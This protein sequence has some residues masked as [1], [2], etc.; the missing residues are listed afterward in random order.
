M[1]QKVTNI[2]INIHIIIL[3]KSITLI[4]TKF[5]ALIE[6]FISSHI[7]IKHSQTQINKYSEKL[8]ILLIEYHNLV[9][10]T[11]KQNNH[12][13]YNNQDL[14]FIMIIKIIIGRIKHLLLE[15]ITQVLDSIHLINVLIYSKIMKNQN[16]LLICT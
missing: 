2:N 13:D 3:I 4:K 15:L 12:L 10:L 8:L 1:I 7:M 9:I 6:I 11:I 5:I 14:I 16:P